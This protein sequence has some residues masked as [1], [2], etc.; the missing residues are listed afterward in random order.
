MCPVRVSPARLV[1]GGQM[2][3]E[4]LTRQ[5]RDRL[6]RP[7]LVE[8]MGR[9]GDDG[10]LVLASQPVLRL[11]IEAEHVHVPAADDQQGRRLHRR[12]EGPAKCGRPPVETTAMTSPATS[13][14]ADSAAAAPAPAPR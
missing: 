14:A 2:G 13:V 8:Q 12:R 9:I 10:Q 11:A 6:E 1:G 4:P 7:R 3:G 5:I